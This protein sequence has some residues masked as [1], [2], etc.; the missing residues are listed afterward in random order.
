MN[1]FLTILLL[2]AAVYPFASSSAMIQGSRE[3][4]ADTIAAADNP[5]KITDL[6]EIVVEGRTQR[7][8]K[9]GVEYTPD[10]RTKKLATGAASLLRLMAIPQLEI[11]LMSNSITMIGGRDVKIFIDYSPAT[12][13]D[14]SGLRTEDVMRVEVLQFPD[15]PRFEGAANV[16]NFIMHKY[17]WGG[18]TLLTADVS[19]INVINGWGSVYSKYVK[20]KWTIDAS[21]G[22]SGTRLDRVE[23]DV[24]E[25][26]RN[27]SIGTRTFDTVDRHSYAYD[28]LYT[29]NSEWASVRAI[30]N[31]PTMNIR[32]SIMF[33]RSDLPHNDK[34]SHVEYSDG[35]FPASDADTKEST[36]AMMPSIS[37]R[38]L[39]ILP[40]NNYLNINWGLGYNRTTR[41][42]IYSL[43]QME[44]I[45]NENRDYSY[46]PSADIYYTKQLG[47][48]NTFRAALT[49]DNSIFNTRY[50]GSYDG[51]QKLLS[52][53]NQ[54]FAEYS[55]SWSNGLSLFSRAGVTYTLARVNGVNTLN[56]WNP[57]LGMEL[58]YYISQKH[59]ASATA[60]WTNNPPSAGSINSAIVQSNELLWLMGNQDLRGTSNRSA[61]LSYYFIPTNT[62]SLAAYVS[63]QGIDRNPVYEFMTLPD[64]D[65]LV[66]RTINSGTRNTWSGN[67]S[68]TLRLLHNSLILNGSIYASRIHLTGIN[69]RSCNLLAPRIYAS[70]MT[71]HFAFSANFSGAAS[72]ILDDPL[73][74]R[75]KNPCTYGVDVTYAVGEFKAQLSSSNWW[76]KGRM[77]TDYDSEHYSSHGWTWVNG[78]TAG[79]NLHL[80]YT[81]TYGKKV[82]RDDQLGKASTG[83]SAILK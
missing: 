40:K 59:I 58:Q 14:L 30:Y 8:I 37:A 31:A 26:F 4:P 35:L 67:V 75:I 47:H 46:T 51:R 50:S 55:E 21:V 10:K 61:S 43:G 81:F 32:H 83:N 27:I 18:Y 3:E 42:S 6:S 66:R 13:N 12:S 34:I 77:Y 72:S 54:I 64:Y 63:Y 29:G 1:R 17:V 80:S 73:G 15:D 69:P 60:W 49:T 52:S 25:T 5:E 70:Y 24:T 68:A 45:I 38:Y 53:S 71:G 23:E 16:V 62:F 57:L 65:G 76:N 78:L 39:F 33:G 9:N 36:L 2:S 7:A 28:G 20:D 74:G 41:N 79:I 56:Q 82:S 22:A 19:A 11:S 44:P 48:N